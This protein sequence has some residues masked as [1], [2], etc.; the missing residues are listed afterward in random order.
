M[1]QLWRSPLRHPAQAFKLATQN[2]SVIGLKPVAEHGGVG[3]AKNEVILQ[4]AGV[5]VVQVGCVVEDALLLETCWWCRCWR[6]DL[7]PA[8]VREGQ[9]EYWSCCCVMTPSIRDGRWM[10]THPEGST[11]YGGAGI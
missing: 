6:F 9:Y 10:P 4:V 3:G 8:K 7:S 5:E 2:G 1:L 11:I